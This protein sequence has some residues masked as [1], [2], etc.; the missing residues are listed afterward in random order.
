[1]SEV[2]PSNQQPPAASC[3]M[4]WIHS[5][6]V[7]RP[8]V[9]CLLPKAFSEFVEES[10]RQARTREQRR[11]HKLKLAVEVLQQDRFIDRELGAGDPRLIVRLS[12]FVDDDAFA[13]GAEASTRCAL[14]AAIEAI[15]RRAPSLGQSG[16]APTPTDS[17]TAGRRSRLCTW[18]IHCKQDTAES[19]VDDPWS[20]DPEAWNRLAPE[21]LK[22]RI[23]FWAG[24]IADR[25]SRAPWIA[26]DPAGAFDRDSLIRD[27]V[28][29]RR[30]VR[31]DG[32]TSSLEPIPATAGAGFECWDQIVLTTLERLFPPADAASL[33]S[34]KIKSPTQRATTARRDRAATMRKRRGVVERLIDADFRVDDALERLK[35]AGFPCSR[36]TYFADQ[37]AILEASTD[38]REAS[39]EKSDE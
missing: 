29:D 16:S 18:T 38:S 21:Q 33:G 22:S 1:M 37:K 3:P 35:I 14:A 27:Y 23:L 20:I 28:W 8:D 34:A 5:F 13:A 15:E 11:L 12:G 25:H 17:G 6:L 10:L 2:A 4:H 31:L 19:D 9:S 39:D 26:R 36:S 24:G 30:S 32:P 7:S